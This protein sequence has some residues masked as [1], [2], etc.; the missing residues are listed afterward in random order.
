MSSVDVHIIVSMRWRV[1]QPGHGPGTRSPVPT[2]AMEWC[3]GE[4]MEVR[5]RWKQNVRVMGKMRKYGSEELELRLLLWAAFS[6]LTELAASS[7]VEIA[8]IAAALRW[9]A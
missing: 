3:E 5:R 1:M 2:F 8:A 7:T 4:E 9:R 6:P